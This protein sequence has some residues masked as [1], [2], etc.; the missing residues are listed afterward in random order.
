MS[1]FYLLDVPEFAP[2]ADAVAKDPRCKVHPVLAGY[3]YVEFD[4]AISIRRRDTGLKEAVWFGCLTAGLDGRI[5]LFTA[6]EIR[7]V[8]TNAPILAGT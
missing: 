4:G 7:L 1:G 8:A 2:L 3:R 6:E 5:A